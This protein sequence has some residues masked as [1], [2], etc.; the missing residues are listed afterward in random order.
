MRT[1]FEDVDE[2]N[3]LEDDGKEKGTRAAFWL[4]AL[5]SVSVAFGTYYW[6]AHRKPPEAPVAAVS[7]NDDSQL[8]L[9]I[10]QFSG[11]VKAGNWDEAQKMISAEGLRRLEVEKKTLRESLL[12]DR[13]K[14]QVSEALL[15]PS[16]SRTPSTA[17]L[18]CAYLFADG[19]T[20]IIPMTLVEENGRLAINSW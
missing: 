18:D 3:D 17:R 16:R 4:V 1:I 14:E 13:S 5:L 6:I 19:E 11:Y 20:R 10:N 2:R 8:N 15:T 12:G 7:L 9:V